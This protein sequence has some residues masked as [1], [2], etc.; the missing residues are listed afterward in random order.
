MSKDYKLIAEAYKTIYSEGFVDPYELMNNIVGSITAGS[1]MFG[2]AS[3]PDADSLTERTIAK[4]VRVLENGNLNKQMLFKTLARARR[5]NSRAFAS[6]LNFGEKGN[7]ENT[8]KQYFIKNVLPIAKKIL[9]TEV[10]D[11][12]NIE[13]SENANNYLLKKVDQS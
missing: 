12:N 7:Y 5:E 4:I 1:T 10:D 6:L 13:D 2:G 8:T 3:S 9:N 11:L